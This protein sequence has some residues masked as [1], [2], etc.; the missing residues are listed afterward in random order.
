MVTLNPADGGISGSH[1]SLMCF[2][3]ETSLTF[4]AGFGF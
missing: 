2:D 1:K 4:S 3:A